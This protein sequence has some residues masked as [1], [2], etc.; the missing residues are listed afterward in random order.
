MPIGILLVIFATVTKFMARKKATQ[1]IVFEEVVS[2]DGP[3]RPQEGDSGNRRR[4]GH[5]VRDQDVPVDNEILDRTERMAIGTVC[6]PCCNGK[7]RRVL[8]AGD[9]FLDNGC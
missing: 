8:E 9:E 1:E 4:D 5:R 3:R 2:A 6:N 7:H